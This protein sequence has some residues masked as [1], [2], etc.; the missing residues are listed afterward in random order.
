MCNKKTI[1]ILFPYRC[2][3]IKQNGLMDTNNSWKVCLVPLIAAIEQKRQAM[4]CHMLQI[5]KH[6]MI[7]SEI[8]SCSFHIIQQLCPATKCHCLFYT[9][10]HLPLKEF[11]CRETFASSNE[12]AH[13]LLW[14]QL[15]VILKNLFSISFRHSFAT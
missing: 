9:C 14:I 11:F 13:A 12:F 2:M 5:S 10:F 6:L 8:A 1:L 7:G 3:V 4:R 15:F